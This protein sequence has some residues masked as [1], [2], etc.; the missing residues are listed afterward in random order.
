MY[1][2]NGLAKRRWKTIVIMKDTMYINSSLLNDFW[3]E[4]MKTANYLRNRLW[5]RSKNHNKLVS[6]E[7]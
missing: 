7:V 6:E 3:I 2:E 1:K 5:T 4:V